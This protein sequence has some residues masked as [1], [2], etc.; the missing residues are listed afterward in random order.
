MSKLL[1]ALSFCVAILSFSTAAQAGSA[2]LLLDARTGEVLASENP[3][4]LNH[5]ASLTKMMS[6]YMVFDAIRAGKISWESPVPISKHAASRPPTKL[7]VKAGDS[8]TVR[9]AVLAMIVKSANDASAAIGEKLGGSEEGF[10][11]LMTRKARALGMMNTTFFNASGL[12][13][14]QQFTTARD[15]STLGVALMRDFPKEYELFATRSF[16]FRGKTIN[17]HNNLMYRYKGMDGIKTGYT[18]AS[19]FN[20][21]SAVE[22]DGRRVIG[23]VMG[24]RTA[25][26]RDRIM[27]KLLDANIRKASSGSQLLVSRSTGVQM[28]L[29][30]LGDEIPVPASRQSAV[31]AVQG[32]AGATGT[33]APGTAAAYAPSETDSK[34]L[35]ANP[36]T[37][38]AP[39][40]QQHTASTPQASSERKWQI[41]IAA[42][43]SAQA[44]MDLLSQARQK[45]GTP[46]EDL[47]TYTEMVTR[48]GV[49]FYR[50]RFTGFETKEEARIACDKLVRQRYD[51]VLMPARG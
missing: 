16:K 6:V 47:D 30:R 20:L 23:V 10:A 14:A 26:S 40:D 18:N 19:G 36:A 42:A 1:I 21:V 46:L 22:H 50:A 9:E 25:A 3:D 45:V 7:F 27:E 34:E 29:A 35:V 4:E 43:T 15:M 37:R 49:T 33:S 17:G 13:H 28:D 8:I 39:V 48:N 51:C 31:A 24:G 41:Q 2:Q 44:A 12:P 11:A 5:P 38:F 32:M